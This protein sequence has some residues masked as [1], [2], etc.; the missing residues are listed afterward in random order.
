MS[1]SKLYFKETC[2]IF[3]LLEYAIYLLLLLQSKKRAEVVLHLEEEICREDRLH[4]VVLC[5]W[6]NFV[7][8][9]KVK[10]GEIKVKMKH[11]ALLFY[12]K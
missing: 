4:K 10:L 7:F 6:L 9:M 5:D 8:L 12:V 11:P 1:R 2:R 3:K